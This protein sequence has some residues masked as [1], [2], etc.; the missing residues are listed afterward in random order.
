MVLD[1]AVHFNTQR[2]ER[3]NPP[4]GILVVLSGVSS[5]RLDSEP[6]S[7]S[8]DSFLNWLPNRLE[9][10]KRL[11]G[12]PIPAGSRVILRVTMYLNRWPDYNSY[13]AKVPHM[14]V[15][16][17]CNITPYSLMLME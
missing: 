14:V 15:Q 10:L 4:I 8:R 5:S 2:E 17:Y 11:V 16:P 7:L 3:R 9:A 1:L 6:C 12:F 13:D